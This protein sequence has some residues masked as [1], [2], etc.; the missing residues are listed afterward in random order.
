MSVSGIPEPFTSASVRDGLALPLLVKPDPAQ[1]RTAE[2]AVLNEWLTAQRSWV[3]EALAVHGGLLFRG[4]AL[5]RP[6]EFHAVVKSYDSDPLP[7]VEGQSQRT[8]VMANIYTSTEYPPDQK[9][10]LHNELSYVQTPPRRLFFFCEI[11][12]GTGGETPIADC[13]RVYERIEPAMRSRFVE[14]GIRY[15]KNMHGGKGFGKSWQDH[16]ETSD[17]SAVEEHLAASG[18]EFRWKPDDTLWT[19]QKRP[20]VIEHPE[21][22]E[23]IWFNQ[24]DLWHYTNLG[25]KGE[26]L[27]RMVG[28]EE[29]PTN[30][31]YGDGTPID[32]ADLAAIREISWQEAT[33]FPWI[34]GD[35]LILDNWLVS[36]GRKSFSGERKIL[37]AM[38]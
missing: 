20:A 24:A 7:Y 22:G 12:P 38:T 18:E 13:R 26:A 10:T 17:R 29:L 16:F 11:A 31:Y 1:P 6:E 37:V 4:F 27:R 23:T 15:V 21:T 34:Q 19:S 2:P 5:T 25:S 36:H 30:A 35:L 8:R 32:A 9:I 14:R 28:E 33:V 3:D